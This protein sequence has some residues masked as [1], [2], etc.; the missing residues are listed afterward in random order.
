MK[1]ILKKT[2]M[3]AFAVG[4][5]VLTGCSIAPSDYGRNYGQ[6]DRVKSVER[7]ENG[8][9]VEKS[10]EAQGDGVRSVRIRDNRRTSATHSS[11]DAAAKSGAAAGKAKACAKEEFKNTP[12]CQGQ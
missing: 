1:A 2:T 8:V 10:T 3:L 7:Y 6:N 12:L 11:S 9:L 4:A 5:L